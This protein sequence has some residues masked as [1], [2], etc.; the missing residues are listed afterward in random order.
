[1]T[2]NRRW[3]GWI[4]VER[5]DDAEEL[6]ALGVELGAYS[7]ED[8]EFAAELDEAAMDKLNKLWGRFYWGLEPV[9]LTEGSNG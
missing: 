2:A 8:H 3:R 5:R 7:S 9:P 1:M 4:I 6:K